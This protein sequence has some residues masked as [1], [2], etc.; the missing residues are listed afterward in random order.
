[1][2]STQARAEVVIRIPCGGAIHRVVVTPGRGR[3]VHLANPDHPNR[4]AEAVLIALGSSGPPCLEV[5]ASIDE[6]RRLG[7]AGMEAARWIAVAGGAPAARPWVQSGY[8]VESA[9]GWIR[10]GIARPSGVVGWR[11]LGIDEPGDLAPWQAIG[12]QGPDEAAAWAGVGVTRPGDVQAWRAAGAVDGHAAEEWARGGAA[13]PAE[14]L[15]WRR[16]GLTPTAMRGWRQAGV[17]DPEELPAWFEAGV[18]NPVARLCWHWAGVGH[19]DQIDRWK[20]VGVTSEEEA[21]RWVRP[22]LI[23]GPEE[24]RAWRDAGV[25][26]PDRA[27]LLIQQRREPTSVADLRAVG[28]SRL[29]FRPDGTDGRVA[30]QICRGGDLVTEVY[31]YAYDFGCVPEM[32]THWHAVDFAG[33][34]EIRNSRRAGL[35]HHPAVEAAGGVA[36]YLLGAVEPGLRGAV[37]L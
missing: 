29:W 35:V 34:D 12:V 25:A 7:L 3:S 17:V 5:R 20:A 23:T 6:L 14:V 22:R 27:R 32:A 31:W 19:P 28:L 37:A 24:I 8:D 13:T 2:P 26:D 16:H 10:A 18:A 21:S 9:A 15:R 11:R 4:D 33:H 36:A 30:T 1:M